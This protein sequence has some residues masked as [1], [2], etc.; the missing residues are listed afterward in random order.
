MIPKAASFNLLG[1]NNDDVK[2]KKKSSIE[3]PV[4]HIRN[5]VYLSILTD[6]MEFSQN[7]LPP[8][9]A[10]LIRINKNHEFLPIVQNDFLRSRLS[11]FEE[12]NRNTSS[13]NLEFNYN[14]VGIGKLRLVL[15]VEHAM[16]SLN[17]LGFTSKDVD[18]VKGIFS[19]TN[20][21]L[22]CGTMFVGS[23][24]V[25]IFDQ[26]IYL[27]SLII[28]FNF[29]SFYSIFYHSKMMYPFGDV[30]NHMQAFH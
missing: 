1:E 9:L 27:N 22:L 19:D 29:F 24:H 15:H 8:E 20:V 12:V 2:P 17:Q 25:S 3:R 30:K 4:T 21:Y 11:D 16:E 7:D 6:N 13:I 18:E 23:I 5:K 10:R 26:F 14:P 28:N